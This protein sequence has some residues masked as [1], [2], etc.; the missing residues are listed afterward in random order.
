MNRKQNKERMLDLSLVT[1]GEPSP[2]SCVLTPPTLPQCCEDSAGCCAESHPG[3]KVKTLS[4]TPHVVGCRFH[5]PLLPG[6]P[7]W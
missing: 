3:V 5:S 1:G 2:R 4:S 7:P 6:R